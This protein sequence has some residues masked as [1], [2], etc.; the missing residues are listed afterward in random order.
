MAVKYDKRSC[1]QY[2]SSLLKNKQIF[3]FTFCSFNDYNSG[4]IKKFIFFLSF[5]LHY[6]VSA[7]FFNEDTFHQI[8]EDGGS[9]NFMFQLPKILFSALFSTVFLRI[10]LETLVLTERNILQ[11]KQQKTYNE[12]IMM[13]KKALKCIKIKFALFFVI[14]FVLL[15]LFW[16][17]L[18]VFN[19]LYPN[20]QLYLIENTAISFGISLFYPIFWNIIP[21]AL[22]VCSLGAKNHN[23]QCI[24]NT[25]KIFQLI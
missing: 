10:M 17:Y 19:A 12:A 15:T 13:K 18:T 21:A 23:R 25:S 24:Y 9:F 16:Y 14:N 4:I 2:Y 1:C 8:Y 22:R 3:M 6:T 11:I 5:A 7:L 20:S